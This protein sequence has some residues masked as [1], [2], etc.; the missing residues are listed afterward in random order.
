M[1]KAIGYSYYNAEKE[2]PR[3]LDSWYP[4]VDYIIALDGRYKTPLS[5]AMSRMKLSDYSTDNTEHLLKTRYPDKIVHERLFATQIE[6]RQR[7]L[8]IAGELGCDY[9]IVWDSDDYIHPQYKEWDFFNKQLE[10]ELKFPN[11]RIYDMWAWIPSVEL[12]PQQHNEVPPNAWR[13]YTRI[14]K[15]PGTMRYAQ[16][17]WT[18]ADKKVTDD[19]INKF[20]WAHGETIENPYYIKSSTTIDGIRFTTDRILRSSRDLEFGDGWAYQNMHWEAYEYQTKPYWK[21]KGFELA[22]ESIKTKKHPNLQY[23]FPP[24]DELGR[25]Y[26]TPYYIN[27]KGE[28]IRIKPDMVEEK[29]TE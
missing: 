9:L 20:L 8:D 25:V 18:F 7:Y 28:Y 16:T 23:Y 13:Q 3:S 4:Q 12:W 6:K 24:P 5:P 22:Y 21:D 29:I 19:D 2:T 15:N 14:H 26:L 27:E 1:K 10:N 11:H 17:H